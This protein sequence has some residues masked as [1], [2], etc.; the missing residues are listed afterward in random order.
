MLIDAHHHLWRYLPEAYSWINGSMELL[1]RDFLPEELKTEMSRVGVTGTIVIQARQV[2]EE[3]RYLLE[4]ADKNPF[5]KG[6]V[7]WVDLCSKEVRRELESFTSYKKLVG[8][9]HVIQ[10]EADDEFMLRPD[11]I[12]GIEALQEYKLTYDLLIFPKHL[13]Y[14]KE[15]VRKFPK[16]HFVIDHMAK[17]LIKSGMIQPWK[18]PMEILATYPNVWCKISGMVTEADP[19]SWK[20]EDFIPYMKVV[21]DAF[22]PDHIMLGSDWPVCLLAGAYEEVLQIP[23]KFIT[24]LSDSEKENIYYRSAMACYQL[25]N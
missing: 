11:F 8:V 23:L 9:R 10:D 22:G 6:V 16:Q 12:R 1:R 3:T 5:I 18:V 17:P 14:A 13:K 21:L 7:G 4:L 25:E 15:L 2:A 20:M 19:V 24:D